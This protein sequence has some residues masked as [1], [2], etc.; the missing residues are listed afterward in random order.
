MCCRTMFA[1]LCLR[2]PPGPGSL[3]SYRPVQGGQDLPS[4]HQKQL[5][6]G[7]VRQGQSET[8]ARQG[9]PPEHEWARERQQWGEMHHTHTHTPI[10]YVLMI[11]LSV[12]LLSVHP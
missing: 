11:L 12:N 8:G 6:E 9:C 3:S 7:D 2:R 4:D 1:C 5:R 10:Q